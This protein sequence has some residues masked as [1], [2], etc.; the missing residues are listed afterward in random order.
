MILLGDRAWC[1]KASLDAG[2]GGH[3]RQVDGKWKR[4]GQGKVARIVPWNA[5]KGA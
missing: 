3:F 5:K 1:A 2:C 4:V